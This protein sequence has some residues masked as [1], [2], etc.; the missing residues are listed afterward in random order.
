M[1]E[2]TTA[3]S[4]SL[5]PASAGEFDVELVAVPCPPPVKPRIPRDQRSLLDLDRRDFIMMSAGVGG[6][7]AAVLLGLGVAKLL[8]GKSEDKTSN[9]TE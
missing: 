3:P 9:G 5:K 6:T 8:Q 7:L 1:T 4:A 2:A